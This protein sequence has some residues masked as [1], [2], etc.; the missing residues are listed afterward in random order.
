MVPAG[1]LMIYTASRKC[2]EYKYGSL[3]CC[4]GKLSF[5]RSFSYNL[6]CELLIGSRVRLPTYNYKVL[7]ENIMLVNAEAAFWDALLQGSSIGSLG[8]ESLSTSS[9]VYT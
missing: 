2:F 9:Q 7:K 3:S 1:V 5:G 8:G 4:K 6:F